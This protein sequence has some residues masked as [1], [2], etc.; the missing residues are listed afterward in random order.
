LRCGGRAGR[1]S[2]PADYHIVASDQVTIG[3]V[4][5]ACCDI[6]GL[7]TTQR[8]MPIDKCSLVE[9]VGVFH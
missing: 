2:Y 4:D 5:R 6:T 9:R 3:V 1:R 7:V 8:P